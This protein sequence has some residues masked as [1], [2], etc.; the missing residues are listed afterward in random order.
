MMVRSSHPANNRARARRSRLLRRASP[1]TDT[2]Q[3]CP[4]SLVCLV[5]KQ[6]LAS[7]RFSPYRHFPN[8]SDKPCLPCL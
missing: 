6:P 1:P 2:F 4:T 5:S 7:P 8:V 3:T